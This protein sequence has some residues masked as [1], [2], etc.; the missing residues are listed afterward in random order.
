MRMFLLDI[1]G[2]KEYNIN[3]VGRT[4]IQMTG[5]TT[6]KTL[7]KTSEKGLTRGRKSG[8]INRLSHEGETAGTAS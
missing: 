5:N 8:I 1:L 6:K 2:Q 7:K 4:M 3:V